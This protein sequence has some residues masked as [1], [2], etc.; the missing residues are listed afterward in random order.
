[1]CRDREMLAH[2]YHADLRVY[3][4]AEQSLERAIGANFSEA[5]RRAD[6]ARVVFERARELLNQHTRWHHCLMGTDFIQ[7]MPTRGA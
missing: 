3:A 7:T 6:R 1:M 5:F 2:R 4:E